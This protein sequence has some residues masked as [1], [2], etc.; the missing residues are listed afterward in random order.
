[1]SFTGSFLP[2]MAAAGF[3]TGLIYSTAGYSPSK[4]VPVSKIGSYGTLS[5]VDVDNALSA[6]LVATLRTEGVTTIETWINPNP[7]HYLL[8]VAGVIP[9]VDNVVEYLTWRAAHC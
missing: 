6:A 4:D 3:R 1:V 5:Q 2:P 7:A 8:N 9:L